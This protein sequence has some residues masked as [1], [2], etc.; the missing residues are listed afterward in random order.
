MNSKS[1][2]VTPV[3]RRSHRISI[4]RLNSDSESLEYPQSAPPNIGQRH[5]TFGFLEEIE[6]NENEEQII[7]EE[8]YTPTKNLTIQPCLKIPDRSCALEATVPAFKKN[9]MLKLVTFCSKN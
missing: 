6:Y 7:D 3:R 8:P 2:P 9:P 1:A 5:V 4:R